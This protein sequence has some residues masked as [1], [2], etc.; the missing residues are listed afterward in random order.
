MKSLGQGFGSKRG[1][2]DAAEAAV[3]N[4]PFRRPRGACRTIPGSHHR[5][6]NIFSLAKCVVR[7]SARIDGS[8]ILELFGRT[9]IASLSRMIHSFGYETARSSD[10]EVTRSWW[11]YYSY[12]GE[13]F[14]VAYTICNLSLIRKRIE[15]SENFLNRLSNFRNRKNPISC[16]YSEVIENYVYN[17]R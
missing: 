7:L 16:I 17:E 5:I 11:N 4:A 15:K 6:S 10:C 9:T 2:V 14:S 12:P 13:K 8:L 1:F 3:A